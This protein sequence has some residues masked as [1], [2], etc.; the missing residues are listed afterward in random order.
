MI[1]AL[2]GLLVAGVVGLVVLVAI[3]AIVGLVFGLALGVVGL[4]FALAFKVLPLLLVGWIV[5]K[6][7][8][9]TDRPRYRISA[10]DQ[11]WLDT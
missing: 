8:Q 10:A 11:R 1:G 3:L 6:L 2:V 4:V 9:K 7:I 5:V